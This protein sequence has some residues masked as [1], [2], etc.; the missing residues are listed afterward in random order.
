[1][2][3]GIPN[4]PILLKTHDPAHCA[5]SPI[6]FA[7]FMRKELGPEPIYLISPSLAAQPAGQFRG[8][9]TEFGGRHSN[10]IRRFLGAP[11]GLPARRPAVDLPF[12]FAEG[13]S[14]QG[15]RVGHAD[16]E[17]AVALA[18]KDLDMLGFRHYA[19]RPGWPT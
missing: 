1:M 3:S 17:R 15:R 2:A 7:M 4:H 8:H 12:K 5:F 9:N 11:P 6:A 18:G 16:A 14:A 10:R 13:G 19:C